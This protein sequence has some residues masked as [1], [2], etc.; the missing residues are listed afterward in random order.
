VRDLNWGNETKRTSLVIGDAPIDPNDELDDP[1]EERHGHGLQSHY[2]DHFLTDAEAARMAQIRAEGWMIGKRICTGVSANPDWAPGQRFKLSGTPGMPELDLEYLLTAV[3]HQA[4]S[5]VGGG[6]YSNS[7]E[8]TDFRLEY[9]SPR[10]TPW[11]RIEGVINARIDAGDI[12]TAAPI[13]DRGFYR[14]I[15]PYDC[16]GRVGRAPTAWLRKAE[17]YAGIDHGLH[18]TLHSGA[19]VLLAHINGDP[20]RPVI[21]GALPNASRPGP[22]KASESTRHVVR[23]RSGIVLDFEDDAS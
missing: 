18:F 21:V 2:G 3:S 17:P 15:L 9:R 20:D 16:Y 12:T 5:S 6:G 10:Q 8:A 7:F 23:T 13:D 22:V 4:T 11:P 14:V 1:P 19:E